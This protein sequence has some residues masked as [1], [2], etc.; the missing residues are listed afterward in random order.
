MRKFAQ[1]V[2]HLVHD[3]GRMDVLAVKVASENGSLEAQQTCAQAASGLYDVMQKEAEDKCG[4]DFCVLV[5]K[6][7][8]ALE[9]PP[10]SPE[11]K[12]KIAAAVVVDNTLGQAPQTVK[13]ARARL[14]GR[15][16]IAE[17]L[18]EAI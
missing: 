1:K 9:L 6:M 7:A 4:G 16:F 8:Q 14:Y 18:R 13:T 15:E 2:S 11:L 5:E 3:I 17:L 12:A 10:V